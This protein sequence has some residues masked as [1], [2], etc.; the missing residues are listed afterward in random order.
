MSEVDAPSL[1]TPPVPAHDEVAANGIGFV[2]GEYMPVNDARISIRENGF[3]CSDATY[4]VVAVWD[5]AFFRLDDHLDRFFRGCERLTLTPPGSREEVREMMFEM[6]RR[7][8]LQRA[9]VQVLATRGVPAAG[10]QRDPRKLTSA[11]YGYTL[12]YLWILPPE[13]HEEGLNLV[14]AR[15]VFRIPPTSVD[16]TVKNFMWGD[17]TRGQFEAYDRGG[18]YCILTDGQGLITEGAGFNVF[19]L[20]DGTLYTPS[21]GILLGITRK[22]CLEIAEEAEIPTAVGSVPVELAERAEEAFIATT[23]GGVV[24]I[25]TLDGR[26]LGSGKEGPV[27]RQIRDTYWEWHFDPRHTVPV[28]YDKAA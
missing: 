16:P 27:T 25:T 20:V 24:A 22:V 10:K 15:S 1:T 7:S 18:T 11:L 9:Y 23:A 21:E 26:K 6:V 13:L 5:G 28:D 19:F 2:E 3:S 4:D 17:F 8:G 14:I 12:P